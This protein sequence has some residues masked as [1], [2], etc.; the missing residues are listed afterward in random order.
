MKRFSKKH[1][2]KIYQE[3]ERNINKVSLQILWTHVAGFE[4]EE[5]P[6]ALIYVVMSY[7]TLDNKT[8]HKRQ[9]Y[10]IEIDTSSK[11]WISHSIDGLL[12]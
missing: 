5:R 3:C 12:G 10:E 9:F 2:A 6:M 1:I 8:R 7:V 11:S 4:H